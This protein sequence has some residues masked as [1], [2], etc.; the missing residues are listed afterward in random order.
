MVSGDKIENFVNPHSVMVN[1]S[2]A[3]SIGPIA[4]QN[5]LDQLL[6]HPKG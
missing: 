1:G 6:P 3:M 2:I 4:D 5:E